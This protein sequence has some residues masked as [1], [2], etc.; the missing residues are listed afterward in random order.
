MKTLLRIVLLVAI[1]AAVVVGAYLLLRRS[2]ALEA[3]PP[4]TDGGARWAYNLA[5]PRARTEALV[6]HERPVAT[7]HVVQLPTPSRPHDDGVLPGHVR[8]AESQV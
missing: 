4:G 8:V 1:V 2:E 3:R 6:V 5:L 7:T